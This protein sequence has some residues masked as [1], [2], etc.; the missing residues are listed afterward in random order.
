MSAGKALPTGVIERLRAL[1]AS[2][3]ELTSA[4]LAERFDLNI[5]TVQRMVRGMGRAKAP[6]S[7]E[8]G[9]I[10]VASCVC[11]WREEGTTKRA[12]LARKAHYRAHQ[13][14]T[15]A[16]TRITLKVVA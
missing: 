13:A 15:R 10:Y 16:V 4:Q 1:K 3:P 9:R 11:G 6:A 8:G 12:S 2:D 5:S 14:G 7:T